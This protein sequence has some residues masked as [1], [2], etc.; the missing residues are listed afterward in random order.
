MFIVKRADIKVIE[1]KQLNTRKAST[2]IDTFSG[3][4]KTT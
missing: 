3:M 1:I 2:I 4:T